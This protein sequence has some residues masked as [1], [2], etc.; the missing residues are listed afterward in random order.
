MMWNLDRNM[1]VKRYVIL[2]LSCS[3]F[4]LVS[5]QRYDSQLEEAL[6][7]AKENRGELEKAL[8]FY[9]KDSLKLEAAKFLIKNMLG[10]YSYREVDSIEKYYDAVDSVL[11]YVQCSREEIRDTLEK[12]S[13]HFAMNY[14]T[15][16]DAVSY[17][18][19]TLPTILRV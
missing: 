14:Y 8:A 13:Q 18:H 16:P 1:F 15:I 2:W 12:V 11:K 9:E 17:T 5:C 4:F 3:L 10:H 19:L 6:I 7:L